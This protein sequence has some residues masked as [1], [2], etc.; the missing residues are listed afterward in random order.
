MQQ[1]SVRVEEAGADLS[2]FWGLAILVTALFFIPPGRPM[3]VPVMQAVSVMV[4]TRPATAHRSKVPPLLLEE[5]MAAKH[6]GA[7]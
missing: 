3:T 5:A 6:R 4:P 2:S 1:R 7:E